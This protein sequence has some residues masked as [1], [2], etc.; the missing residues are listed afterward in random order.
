MNERDV[1]YV[2]A[3]ATLVVGLAILLVGEAMGVAGISIPVGGVVALVGVGLLA[4]LIARAPDQHGGH[5][6]HEDAAEG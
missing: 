1:P 5:E 3:V 6:D 2:V 4:L